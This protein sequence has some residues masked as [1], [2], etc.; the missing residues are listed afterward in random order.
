MADKS[1]GT[2]KKIKSIT[3]ENFRSID[4]ITLTAHDYMLLV[5]KNN[6]GKS[7]IIDALRIALNDKDKFNDVHDRSKVSSNPDDPKVT[8]EIASS[9][10]SLP[11]H[12]QNSK[13]NPKSPIKLIDIPAMT[14]TKDEMK[15]SGPSAFRDLIH[16][17][18][19]SFLES[20]PDI[21]KGIE[22]KYDELTKQLNATD[23][24]PS[25][26]MNQLNEKIKPWGIETNLHTHPNIE[27]LKATTLKFSD[28]NIPNKELELEDFGHGFQRRMIY[29]LIYALALQKN[30]SKDESLNLMLFDEPELYMH[31]TQQEHL[32]RALQDLSEQDNY[33]VI[34]A[35][36]SPIFASKSVDKELTNSLT[37]CQRLDGKTTI[38][39]AN[40]DVWKKIA[41]RTK[42]MPKR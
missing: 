42:E 26:I 8:L 40:E 21:E 6:A 32:A 2:S 23:S 31:P 4:K 11:Y 28:E 16:S 20:H 33:Q 19:T 27:V 24:E 22:E 36:H 3:I 38:F 41:E 37:R 15:T 39:Q 1:D 30:N 35:T 29:E 14:T 17:L 34:L 7:A 25:S 9:N 12:L 18:L 5:G 13:N 10:D